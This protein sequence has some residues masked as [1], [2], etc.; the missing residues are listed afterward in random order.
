MFYEQIDDLIKYLN[1]DKKQHNNLTVLVLSKIK[2][3]HLDVIIK[4]FNY[5]IIS[6]FGSDNRADYALTI[7]KM[8]EDNIIEIKELH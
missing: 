8:I 4:D 3:Q 7:D 2:Q 6:I 5:K 1:L